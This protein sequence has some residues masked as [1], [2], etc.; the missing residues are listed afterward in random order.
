ML[1]DT[2]CFRTQC[3]LPY[4]CKVEHISK[5]L[6]G[7]L[8]NARRKPISAGNAHKCWTGGVGIL[9]EIRRSKS[10]PLATFRCAVCVYLQWFGTNLT[11][12][13][14]LKGLLY[15]SGLLMS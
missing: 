3:A 9:R 13:R 15:R 2:M 11:C 4:D 14:R 12:L 7:S 1:Q 5:V 6:W 8:D 10:Q